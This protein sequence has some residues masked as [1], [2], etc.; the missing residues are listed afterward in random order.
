MDLY[1]AL[2]YKIPVVKKALAILKSSSC[3]TDC[4][5][6]CRICSS[7]GSNCSNCSNC[8]ESADA[9]ANLRKMFPLR[10][11]SR[12]PRPPC[13]QLCPRL[14]P[15]EFK[16]ESAE[17]KANLL[18]YLPTFLCS[19]IQSLARLSCGSFCRDASCASACRL[20]YQS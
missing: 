2:C 6:I 12:V 16:G 5:C 3:K 19:S 17:A 4:I 20:I 15:R 11:A 10:R 8:S 14:C 7:N 9:K 18:R 13:P 1:A